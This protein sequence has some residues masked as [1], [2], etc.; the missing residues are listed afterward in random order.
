MHGEHTESWSNFLV[1]LVYAGK[2]RSIQE[3][4]GYANRNASIARRMLKRL[5]TAINQQTEEDFP[6]NAALNV[7]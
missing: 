7:T 1:P 6:L 4:V 3:M 5:S 2:G